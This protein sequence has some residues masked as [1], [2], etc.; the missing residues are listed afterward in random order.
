MMG[1][2]HGHFGMEHCGPHHGGP[3]VRFCRREAK[4]L[5][6]MPAEA[7]N[8]GTIDRPLGLN[9]TDTAI[10]GVA[11]TSAE[12]VLAPGVGEAIIGGGCCVHLSVEYMPETTR[13]L[14]DANAARRVIVEVVDSEGTNLRWVKNFTEGYHVQEGII[15]TYPGATLRVTV[16]AAIARVRWCEVFAC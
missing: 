16:F 10:V 12:T 7:K 15:T 4:E 2:D 14:P 5:L 8:T 11:G 13:G 9:T 3:P 1:F 6:V